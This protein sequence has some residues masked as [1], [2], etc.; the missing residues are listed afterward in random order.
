MAV[1][2]LLY[3]V[4]PLALLC[5]YIRARGA[6]PV[7]R[8]VGLQ[9]LIAAPL[10]LAA[11]IMDQCDVANLWLY[12]IYLPIE[13]VLLL[14]IA[15]HG[16]SSLMKW[17]ITGGV[18]IGYVICYLQDISAGPILQASLASWSVLF[19]SLVFAPL[20]TYRL[21]RLA[22]LEERKL[23][24]VPEFWLYLSILFYFGGL[25]PYIGLYNY[26]VEND[27]PVMDDLSVIIS[28]LCFLRYALTGVACLCVS[29][30]RLNPNRP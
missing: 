26:L 25:V 11:L 28:T 2:L 1:R 21:F 6:G 18:V 5:W 12:N 23:W 7:F 22:Q 14:S 13:M 8:L 9:L 4:I 16:W 29:P 24:N 3:S 30:N 10:E 15:V 17:T 20:Y 19:T 27:R